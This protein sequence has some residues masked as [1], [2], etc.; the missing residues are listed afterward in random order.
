MA[1]PRAV[2]VLLSAVLV[3]V[4]ASAWWDDEWSGPWHQEHSQPHGHFGLHDGL[5]GYHYG[6]YGFHHPWQNWGWGWD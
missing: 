1:L 2:L 6:H 5:F 4:G 3:A